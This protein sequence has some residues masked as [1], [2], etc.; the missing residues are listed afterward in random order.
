MLVSEL[1]VF[2]YP[3]HTPHCWYLAVVVVA[4]DDGELMTA[5]AMKAAEVEGVM[6]AAEV[7][8][9]MKASEVQG[10]VKASG[11][12][13]SRNQIHLKMSPNWSF[14]DLDCHCWRKKSDSGRNHQLGLGIMDCWQLG[15]H[16]LFGWVFLG[17]LRLR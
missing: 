5:E 6:K 14:H 9:V 15:L 11:V 16:S 1:L 13:G 3:I 10:V 2:Y 4:A 7:E 17:L 12:E 8:G